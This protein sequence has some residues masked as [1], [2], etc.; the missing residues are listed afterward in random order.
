MTEDEM[1]ANRRRRKE[2]MLRR[3]FVGGRP[4]PFI[5]DPPSRRERRPLS[6]GRM[7]RQDRIALWFFVVLAGAITWAAWF[8]HSLGGL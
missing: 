1:K 5:P 2:W 6:L 3:H 4:D 8:V 7:T